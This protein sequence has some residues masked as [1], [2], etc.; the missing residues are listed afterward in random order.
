MQGMSENEIGLQP[1]HIIMDSIECIKC[2]GL[3]TTVDFVCTRKFCPPYENSAIN[4]FCRAADS[5]QEVSL[6]KS[7]SQND[8]D[9]QCVTL[10]VK[11]TI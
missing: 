6:S 3:V 7:R 4:Y 9:V 5:I 11:K 8:H 10:Y 1:T 2:Y